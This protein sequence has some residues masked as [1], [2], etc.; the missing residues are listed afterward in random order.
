MSLIQATHLKKTFRKGRGLFSR[1]LAAPEIHAVKDLSFAVEEGEFV[2]FLGPNGAGKSTTIK[3]MAGIL[4]PTSGEVLVDG[5]SPQS[6]RIRLARRI[7]VVFG[8][9][10]QLWWDLPVK[11]SF[12]ILRAMYRVPSADFSRRLDELTALLELSAFMDTPVRQLSLGQRMR[13]ELAA[14]MLHGPKILFLDEPT[15]GLDVVA[16]ATTRQFLKALNA[17][18]RTTVILTTHD[19][20]DVEELASRILVIDLGEKV[21]DGTVQ[22]LHAHV[23]APSAMEIT[24]SHPPDLSKVDERDLDVSTM[25]DGLTLFV[26]F[27]RSRLAAPEVL[28]RMRRVGDIVDFSLKE[29][30]LESVIRS[31]Y[32]VNRESVGP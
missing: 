21:F 4:H 25:E 27:N 7:G 3:M 10:T 32:T 26:Q 16:K 12:R 23:G 20:A 19:M 6:D 13:A 18:Y 28:E 24:F 1:R 29:P 22:E 31:F 17:T 5:L 30:H 8:Q 15:I 11:E 14:A 9:R 2:G